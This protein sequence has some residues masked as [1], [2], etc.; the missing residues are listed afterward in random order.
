MWGNCSYNSAMLRGDRG[1]GKADWISHTITQTSLAQSPHSLCSEHCTAQ[2]HSDVI[3]HGIEQHKARCAKRTSTHS[4]SSPVCFFFT[5]LTLRTKYFF[6]SF[7]A[8]TGS[9]PFQ[10]A[11]PKMFLSL[12][13]MVYASMRFHISKIG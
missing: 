4:L 12:K 3:W 5:P 13:D 8:F 9:L 2:A 11:F 1:S 6:S 10:C 7:I